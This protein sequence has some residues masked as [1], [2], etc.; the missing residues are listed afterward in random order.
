MLARAALTYG[1]VFTFAVVDPVMVDLL[2]SALAALPPGDSTLRARLLARLAGALQPAANSEEP[3]RI[4]REAIATARRLGDRRALL[5]TMFDGLSALMDVV[6][7]RERRALNLE[8]ESLALAEGDRERLL[9]THARLAIDH[10][11]LGEF[12]LAD[13]RI[14]AFETLAKELRASW[15]LWRAP[16]FR[17]V[18]ATTHG[19]FAEAAEFEEQARDLARSVRDPQ[20]DRAL[21]LLREG[22]LRT[23]ERHDEM[24]A[25]DVLARRERSNFHNSLVVQGAGS[26]LMFT[27]LEDTEQAR[28][29]LDIVPDE[30]WLTDILFV[31]FFLAEPTAFAGSPDRVDK[32]YLRLLPW[33]DQYVM[34]GMTQM[35]WEGPVGRLLAL[36]ALASNVG[37]TPLLTFKMPSRDSAVLMRARCWRGRTMNSV[38]PCGNAVLRAMP[39]ARG[40]SSPRGA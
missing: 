18:R 13:A 17:A 40:L 1:R 16:L 11:A 19:R 26:A 5:E 37:T 27:R 3:V 20:A 35:Q 34:L 6:D 23:A 29:Q 30:W 28:R 14:D 38:A 9:R 31:L 7:P 21:I 2:E 24:R 10:L 39:I 32:L 4:A 8:V 12:A 25:L 36:L 33:A 15:I 22:L